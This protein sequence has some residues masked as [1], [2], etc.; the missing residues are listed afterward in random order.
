[1]MFADRRGG[2]GFATVSFDDRSDHVI[3]GNKKAA[4]KAAF[5]LFF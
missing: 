4:R 1:M 5:D 3:D 2:D